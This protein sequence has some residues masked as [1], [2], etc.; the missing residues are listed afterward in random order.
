MC[1]GIFLVLTLCGFGICFVG[2]GAE[3]RGWLLGCYVIGLSCSFDLSTC[4][5]LWVG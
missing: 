5:R 1:C 4:R 2:D 3:I